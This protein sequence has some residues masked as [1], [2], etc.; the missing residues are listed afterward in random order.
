METPTLKFPLQWHLWNALPCGF[1]THQGTFTKGSTYGWKHGENSRNTCENSLLHIVAYCCTSWQ[2]R[3]HTALEKTS[4]EGLSLQHWALSSTN[5]SILSL[6]SWQMSFVCLKL[7][8]KSVQGLRLPLSPVW[9]TEANPEWI[10]YLSQRISNKMARQNGVGTISTRSL[11][12]IIS[13]SNQREIST[14]LKKAYL[15]QR[16]HRGFW[17]TLPMTWGVKGGTAANIVEVLTVPD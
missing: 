17:R 6:E 2:L 13:Q 7:A 15:K 4:R 9:L 8:R 5:N 1:G 10:T 16:F 11:P 3:N 14:P 12:W